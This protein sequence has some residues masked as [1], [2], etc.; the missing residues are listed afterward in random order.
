MHL[1]DLS[2]LNRIMVLVNAAK[3]FMHR[4]NNFQWDDDYP[5][6]N[7][8][9]K[10]IVN[11]DLYVYKENGVIASFICVNEDIPPEYLSLKWSTSPNCLVIHRMVTHVD[12]MG[13]GLALKMVKFAIEKALASGYKSVWTD[14]NSKNKGALHLFEKLG[15][16]FVGHIVLRQ[17]KDLFCC[18][19]LGL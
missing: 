12:M 18:Y 14:T 8:F 5:L 19:E 17:K 13:Q 9:E 11:Q 10:D 16:N 3:A 7:T 6:K 1:A 2:D 4:H 15:F